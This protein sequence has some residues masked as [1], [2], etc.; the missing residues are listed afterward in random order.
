M[1]RRRRPPSRLPQEAPNDGSSLGHL[2][3]A[4]LIKEIARRRLARGAVDLSAAEAF[5]EEVQQR[6]GE[7]SLHALVE[8]LPPED[9][10]PRPCPR[11]GRPVPVKVRNRPRH[12]LT[13]AGELRVV[14]NYH[15][16]DACN[17]GFHP[18]D[19]EL[20]LPEN[21]DVSDAMERR[22]LDFGVNDTF[23]AAAERWGIHYPFEISSNLVRRVVDRVGERQDAAASELTLQQAYRPTT[24]DLP[25]SLIIA[26]DG[27]MLL[28]REAGWKEAKVAVVARG[29][30]F[31]REKN[32]TNVAE[33]RYV[34]E[35]AQEDF[36][37]SL[38]AALTAERADEVQRVAW[39]GDGAPENWTMA[40]DQC[41]TAIQILDFPHAVQNAMACA[42]KLLG[43]D[44][45][46]LP[47]WQRRI[48]QILMASSPD[49]AIAEL[50]DCLP[51]TT[52]EEQVA[53]LDA[54]V[55]YYRT[56]EGRMRYSEFRAMGLP[57]GSGIVESAHRHVLQVRMK[58]AGQRWSL[59]R[60]RRMARLRAAYRT[61]GPRRFHGAIRAG[62][63][64][65]P[66]RPNTTLPNGARR[67]KH[68]YHPS[69]VSPYGRAA[70][71]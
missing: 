37:R 18:R 32:R 58:R 14:R 8:S 36:R 63:S 11:C 15:H 17:F 34:A 29:E 67:A 21:G 38:R 68:S 69:R 49:V 70:S 57:I 45:L 19:R 23:D 65:P 53:A 2:S 12:V 39:L 31:L 71:N 13:I 59:K 26:T 50:M 62:L 40:D 4:E 54:L 51:L 55:G 42:K 41:P 1:S 7:E 33:A 16:C 52:T 56:N 61:A 27:G 24:E 20:N 6:A 43:E 44:D 9:G 47:L 25:S 66:P 64:P 60:A 48:E 35:F 3:E 22:I 30:A 5:A 28:S 46:S 10:A